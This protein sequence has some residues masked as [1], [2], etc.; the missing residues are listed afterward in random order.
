M[1]LSSKQE[2]KFIRDNF[3]KYFIVDNNLVIIKTIVKK[4]ETKTNLHVLP[5]IVVTLKR[6]PLTRNF[7]HHQRQKVIGRNNNKGPPNKYKK[8]YIIK[9]LYEELNKQF[10]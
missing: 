1:Q 8:A 4:Q 5:T 10:Y 7:Y 2:R 9:A 6:I 3:E